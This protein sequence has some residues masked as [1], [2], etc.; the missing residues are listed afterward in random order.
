MHRVPD[1]LSRLNE[2]DP[3]EDEVASFEEIADPWYIKRIEEI[4][5]D[6]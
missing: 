1:A 3:E 5:E 6:L 2:I 4:H